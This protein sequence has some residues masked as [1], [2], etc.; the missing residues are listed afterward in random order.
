MEHLNSSLSSNQSFEQWKSQKRE[1]VRRQFERECA[2]L[3]GE[4]SR[5]ER[6]ISS[7]N[8]DGATVETNVR[9]T[10]K[11]LY[12]VN[13]AL[14]KNIENFLLAIPPTD[15]GI[16]ERRTFLPTLKKTVEIISRYIQLNK[17]LIEAVQKL[18]DRKN[19]EIAIYF[20]EDKEVFYGPLH[21][22][23]KHSQQEKLSNVENMKH[24]KTLGTYRRILEEIYEKFSVETSEELDSSTNI[25]STHI[26]IEESNGESNEGLSHE[27]G[28]RRCV[29]RW[30]IHSIF[31]L[32][33][34]GSI[35]FFIIFMGIHNRAKANEV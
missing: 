34:L 6:L 31:S 18:H 9:A 21:M 24:H 5:K 7:K 25:V 3:E 1:T 20:G 32:L 35:L 8:M 26:E 28:T 11:T 27:L 23:C 2:Q 30:C 10:E 15:C 16:S 33:L 19:Q 22:K 4:V 29:P 12:E 13:S 17:S 14:C